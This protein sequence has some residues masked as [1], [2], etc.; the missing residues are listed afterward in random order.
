MAAEVLQRSASRAIDLTELLAVLVDAIADVTDALSAE[1]RDEAMEPLD[2]LALRDAMCQVEKVA[3]RAAAVTAS[4]AAEWD[5][6]R[7][8][9]RDGHRSAT[10]GVSSA[11]RVSAR[12][13]RDIV[14][15]GRA[16]A[17]MPTATSAVL[18]GHI[19][20][21]H[22]DLLGRADQPWRHRV[23]ADHEQLLVEQMSSLRWADATRVVDYWVH[24]VDADASA[25]DARLRGLDVHCWASPTL[26]EK[27]AVGAVLDPV[28]GEIFRNEL[29]RLARIERLKDLRSGAARTPTQCRAAALV[30]MAHRSASLPGTAAQAR[31]L[32]TVLVGDD[33]ARHL[34]QLA[35]GVVLH[36]SE[37]VPYVDAALMETVLF[38]S[39]TTVVGVSAQRS[40]TG[41]LRRAIVARDKFCTHPSGCDVPADQCD[42]DHIVPWSHGGETRQENGRA[43]CSTHNRHP[44]MVGPPGESAPLTPI[45][46]DHIEQVRRRWRTRHGLSP[47]ASDV[48]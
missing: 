9:R 8:W 24:R 4:L 22:F 38:D 29:D 26:D 33:T 3:S 15:R 14:R 1:T 44:D 21:D 32:F 35:S 34:C 16:M 12:R 17:A 36:P 10:A 13:A 41:A 11:A 18:G 37:L 5:A 6:R 28:G 31:P 25:E 42:I 23:F 48:A 27:V 47:P 20:I 45:R 30:E 39:P 43:R 7:A 19:D 46:R 40:F 2:D